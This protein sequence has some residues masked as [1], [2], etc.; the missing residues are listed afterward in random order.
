[1][2]VSGASAS[3]ALQSGVA[4]IQRGQEQIDL[5]AQN[6]AS[7]ESKRPATETDEAQKSTADTRQLETSRGSDEAAD[8]DVAQKESQ[9]VAESS[10]STEDNLV[11]LQQGERQVEVSAKVVESADEALGSII[12]VRA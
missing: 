11:Q 12:D 4:G 9:V 5:A 8:T 6:I 3:S 10:S 2:Q 7:Q 1:M